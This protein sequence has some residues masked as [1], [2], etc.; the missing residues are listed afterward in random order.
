MHTQ[1]QGIFRNKKVGS[2]D[3]KFLSTFNHFFFTAGGFSHVIILKSKDMA[4]LLSFCQQNSTC[5][6]FREV[7]SV[8][9]FSRAVP[10]LWVGRSLTL[11]CLKN[12]THT[13][14]KL[15]LMI[16]THIVILSKLIKWNLRSA[17]SM[18]FLILTWTL[19]LLN[20]HCFFGWLFFIL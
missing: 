5:E 8:L 11:E 4:Q 1:P 12:H 3:L 13:H 10:W 19:S 14:I 9:W 17:L 18:N 15:T 7:R 6:W 16:E 2:W 20:N